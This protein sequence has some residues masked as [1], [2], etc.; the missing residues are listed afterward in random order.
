MLL[1]EGFIC[2]IVNYFRIH[3]DV[4]SPGDACDTKIIGVFW[5]FLIVTKW[6][7][8]LLIGTENFFPF[9]LF[10]LREHGMNWRARPLTC[11]EIQVFK[12]LVFFLRSEGC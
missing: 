5:G 3:K 7:S 11:Q 9:R 1:W 8:S 12:A 10:P 2:H 6:M 4:S